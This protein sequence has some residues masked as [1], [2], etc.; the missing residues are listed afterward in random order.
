MRIPIDFEV[1]DNDGDVAA[2]REGQ[3]DYSKDAEGTSYSNFSVWTYTWINDWVTAVDNNKQSVNSYTLYQNYPNPF[4]PTTQI[5]YSI[6]KAG[7]VTLNV[8][9]VLG[10][11]V[12]SL[13]NEYQTAGSHTL[14]FNAASLASGIYFYRLE[15]GN[16]NSVKKMILM[17]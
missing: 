2:Q 12:A 10:R 1:S 15:A 5:N 17:K 9:D 7:M 8:Y 3:L 14:N 11:K 16:Y 4:N 6:E 13:I